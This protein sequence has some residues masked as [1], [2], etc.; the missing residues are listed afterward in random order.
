MIPVAFVIF[1]VGVFIGVP[2]AF[3]LGFA[4]V[5]YIVVSG[6]ANLNVMPTLLFGAM[7]SF[8][9]LAIPFFIMAGELMGRSG[10]LQRLIDLAKALLGPLR[11]GLALV[12]VGASMVMGGI[13]GVSLADAAAIGARWR[14]RSPSAPA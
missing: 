8:P 10:M 7:D 12:N 4:S 2:V 5:L 6:Q 14:P 11:G 9:L 3:A 13:S 1:L